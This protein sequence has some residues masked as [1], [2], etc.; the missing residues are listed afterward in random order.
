MAEALALPAGIA[1]VA[2]F[3]SLAIQLGQGLVKLKELH[4]KLRDAPDTLNHA[5]LS[6]MTIETQLQMIQT[7][8]MSSSSYNSKQ[9]LIDSPLE[10]CHRSIRKV[11]GVIDNIERK[12]KKSELFGKLTVT[13]KD[14]EMRELLQQLDREQSI[15]SI[16]VQIYAESSSCASDAFPDRQYRSRSIIHILTAHR[17]STY[18][19]IA[20]YLQRKPLG[21][22][23]DTQI[24]VLTG[25][26]LTVATQNPALQPG[27]DDGCC[28]VSAGKSA[29]RVQ[30]REIAKSRQLTL[31]LRLWSFTKVYS[32]TTTRALYGWNVS[33]LVYNIVPTQITRQPDK[34]KALIQYLTAVTAFPDALITVSRAILSASH[35]CKYNIRNRNISQSLGAFEAILDGCNFDI[36]WAASAPIESRFAYWAFDVPELASSVARRLMSPWTSI[37]TLQERFEVA[38]RT[39]LLPTDTNQL[40]LLCGVNALDKESAALTYEGMS[41]LHMAAVTFARDCLESRSLNS[42]WRL[43]VQN[44]IKLGADIHS[45]NNREMLNSGTGTPS[46]AYIR[47]LFTYSLVAGMTGATFETAY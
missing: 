46:M 24:R 2:G 15:L 14:R 11:N 17:Y 26:A 30:R 13:L 42:P 23:E 31:R 8:T 32:V 6:I 4:R 10:L 16:A 29:Q 5:I 7:Y 25:N 39:F 47:R 9:A 43:L 41:L 40:L 36:D 45:Q 28:V 35:Q 34:S 12:W 3:A 21:R 18:C 33:L 22:I 19:A 20:D 1:G 44:L 37:H 27:L 38:A